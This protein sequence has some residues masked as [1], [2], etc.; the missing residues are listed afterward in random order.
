MIP[1]VFYHQDGCKTGGSVLT[2]L[3]LVLVL[4][5]LPKAFLLNNAILANV[6]RM[7][8]RVCEDVGLS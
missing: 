4:S 7:V 1:H 5:F 8:A 6:L 3:A 2:R